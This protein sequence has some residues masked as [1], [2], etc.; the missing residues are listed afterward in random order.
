MVQAAFEMAV[1]IA[2]LTRLREVRMSTPQGPEPYHEEWS[3]RQYDQPQAAG[4]GIAV[5]TK[6]SPLAFGLVLYKP[7]IAVDGHRVPNTR[8]GRNL[9]PAPPGRHQVHV[10]T[11]FS[12]T[13]G[14]RVRR[15]GPTDTTV[16]VY[17]GRLTELEYRAPVFMLCRGSLGP[18]PQK[19]HGTWIGI[20]VLALIAIM[21]FAYL[22]SVKP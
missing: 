4:D 6:Y 22:M 19:Y 5:T 15:I 1:A 17:P 9:I 7:R 14:F 13:L 20:T 3:P 2:P 18:P 8:W 11:A 21:M 16:D 12:S 10:Y